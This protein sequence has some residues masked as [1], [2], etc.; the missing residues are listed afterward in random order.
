MTR[1]SYIY[2]DSF[3]GQYEDQTEKY[4]ALVLE[5]NYP[6]YLATALA[7]VCHLF[8]LMVVLPLLF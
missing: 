3:A 6:W 1:T 2:T 7:L 5:K 8:G 4:G